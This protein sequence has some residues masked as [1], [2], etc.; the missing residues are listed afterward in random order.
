MPT[1]RTETLSRLLVELARLNNRVLVAEDRLLADLGLSSARWR[2]LSAIAGSDRSQ[3]VAWI[4]RDLG[5]HRQN[6]LRIV[7][8]LVRDG[9]LSL[10][11]NPHHRRAQLVVLTDAGRN[12]VAGASAQIRP[13]VADLAK[14]A[15][16]ADLAVAVRVLSVL[17]E[18]LQ[19]DPDASGA[20]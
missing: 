19:R 1:S 9:L 20:Q 2:V 15:S 16:A 7:N 8:E 12:V 14:Q 6:T 5:A 11:P 13:V 17:H 4:A 10:E 3:P 18:R